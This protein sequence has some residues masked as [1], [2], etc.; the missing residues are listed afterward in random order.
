MNRKFL[1]FVLTLSMLA[2]P[3]FALGAVPAKP[4]AANQSASQSP[5]QAK[6]W[7]QVQSPAPQSDPVH[8]RSYE[9]ETRSR[10]HYGMSKKEKVFLVAVAGTSMSIGAI[11]GGAEGLA[12]GAI[13]GGWGAYAVHRLWNHIR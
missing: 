6:G 11:A 5:A 4:A 13:V 8:N 12:I 7:T 9:R 1:A 2:M 3:L 10:R